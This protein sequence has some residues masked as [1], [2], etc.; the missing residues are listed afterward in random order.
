M[1][2]LRPLSAQPC[3]RLKTRSERHLKTDCQ[4]TFA[5]FIHFSL[6]GHRYKQR[7]I[8]CHLLELPAHARFRSWRAQD[9]LGETTRYPQRV[10]EGL[11]GYLWGLNS[12]FRL[13]CS[14]SHYHLTNSRVGLLP[15]HK[16]RLWPR[17]TLVPGYRCLRCSNGLGAREIKGIHENYIF[18]DS[19][20]GGGC[21]LSLL[22]PFLLF[23]LL[24]FH[25]TVAACASSSVFH[26]TSCVLRVDL[27]GG[28]T[29]P[30]VLVQGIPMHTRRQILFT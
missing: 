20:G 24:P 15:S 9:I 2:R 7:A 28:Q 27:R 22:I 25:I 21:V 16:A 12:C 14:N 17:E 18:G 1:Q 8:S 26:E 4:A 3:P 10:S 23:L 19:Q 5:P 13:Q 29:G 6:S 11:K 30:R